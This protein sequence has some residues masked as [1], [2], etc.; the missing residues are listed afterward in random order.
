MPCWPRSGSPG[1]TNGRLP[2]AR[3]SPKSPCWWPPT[4]APPSRATLPPFESRLPYPRPSGDPIRYRTVARISANPP[5]NSDGWLSFRPVIFVIRLF[6]AQAG[7]AGLK[8]GGQQGSVSVSTRH[9]LKPLPDPVP[10]KI[11]LPFSPPST[12]PSSTSSRWW[13][14]TTP[15]SPGSASRNSF[16]RTLMTC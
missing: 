1:P 4:P 13:R 6:G 2:W 15:R 7:W 8:L 9:P 16:K 10:L 3:R 12:A 5:S 14:A 11:R